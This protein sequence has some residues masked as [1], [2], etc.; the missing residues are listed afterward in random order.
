MAIKAVLE[1]SRQDDT[2]LAQQQD[3]ILADSRLRNF[4]LLPGPNGE[5]PRRLGSVNAIFMAFLLVPSTERQHLVIVLCELLTLVSGLMMPLP[6]VLLLQPSEST[7][8]KLWDQPPSLVDCMEAIAVVCICSFGLVVF[9]S[10]GYGFMVV[11]SGYRAEPHFYESVIFG[12]ATLFFFM[13]TTGLF[14]TLLLMFWQRFTMAVSPYPLIG[15]AVFAY[16]ATMLCN[17]VT[18]ITTLDALTLEFYHMPPFLTKQMKN[19]PWLWSRLKDEIILD[20][21][22]KRAAHLRA[23]VGLDEHGRVVARGAAR[24]A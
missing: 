12:I 21:A 4:L 7:P 10:V 19:F 14:P 2:A 11:S 17:T 24:G 15:A 3:E 9:L 8:E 16:A 22:Q 18:N 1:E 5:A 6:I 13:L 20:K 23:L